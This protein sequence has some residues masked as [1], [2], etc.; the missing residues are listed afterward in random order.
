[1]L[2]VALQHIIIKL[3]TGQEIQTRLAD[4]LQGV[5]DAFIGRAMTVSGGN[6]DSKYWEIVDVAEL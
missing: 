6:D 4:Q 3:Q 5:L 2:Q 1:M